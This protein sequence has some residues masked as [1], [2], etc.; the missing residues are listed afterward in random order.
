M[1][2]IPQ[3][4][5]LVIFG[6]TGD[7]A[8]RKLIPALYSLCNQKALEHTSVL[9]I[10]RKP[11]GSEEFRTY[12]KSNSIIPAESVHERDEFLKKIDYLELPMNEPTGYEP[13]RE[14]IHSHPGKNITFYLSVPQ[15]LF[16]P[17][18]SG[19]AH[20]G[21]NT[22]SSRVAFEKPFGSDLESATKLNAFV[23]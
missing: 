17:I 11:F 12:L 6:A 22:P 5:L 4:N 15:E 14:F 18:V 23:A 1:S 20:I 21:L 7:L 3:N 8:K 19:I 13:L 10:G 2:Q 16:K 9:A